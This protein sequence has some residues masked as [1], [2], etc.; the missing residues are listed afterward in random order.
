MQRD[1]N[2]AASGHRGGSRFAYTSRSFAIVTRSTVD[3]NLLH[4][5]SMRGAPAQHKR[6]EASLRLNRV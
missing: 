6:A 3:K 5:A 1:F 2:G 4:T